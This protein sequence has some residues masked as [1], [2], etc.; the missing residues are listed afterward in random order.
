MGNFKTLVVTAFMVTL[1]LTTKSR[2]QGDPSA[3]VK[4]LNEVIVPI[5]TMNPDSS[6]SDLDFLKKTLTDRSIVSIGEA[7]HGTK[8]FF[9]YKDRLFSV[10]SV[11]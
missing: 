9:V 6:F 4:S 8:E 1:F 2:G 5:R 10:S 7:T 3:I 11:I